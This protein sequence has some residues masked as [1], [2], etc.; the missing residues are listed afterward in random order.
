M[1]HQ[2]FV[3]F[4]FPPSGSL[5]TMHDPITV[6][7]LQNLYLFLLSDLDCLCVPWNSTPHL[8][9]PWDPRN[10]LS[11]PTLMK[12]DIPGV[13]GSEKHCPRAGY[14]RLC[15]VNPIKPVQFS[16]EVVVLSETV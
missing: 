3:V 8:L 7:T 13:P 11:H 16:R 6:G 5:V 9:D 2:Q 10:C 12:D 4:R 1:P 15:S 14:L